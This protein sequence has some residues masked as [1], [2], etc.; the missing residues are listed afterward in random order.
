MVTQALLRG[1]PSPRTRPPAR[2]AAW[3]LSIFFSHFVSSQ[4]EKHP[5]EKWHITNFAL[6]SRARL[7]PL[8]GAEAGGAALKAPAAPFEQQHLCSWRQAITGGGARGKAS[9]FYFSSFVKLKWVISGFFGSSIPPRLIMPLCVTEV[10]TH[11]RLPAW[12]KGNPY[13]ALQKEILRRQLIAASRASY[14]AWS[15]RY[16]T[17][18]VAVGAGEAAACHRPAP[19]APDCVSWAPPRRRAEQ[20]TPGAPPLAARHGPGTA[21]LPSSPLPPLYCP[22]PVLV[23]SVLTA[24]WALC[25]VV[26]CNLKSPDERRYISSNRIYGVIKRIICGN[27]TMTK[28]W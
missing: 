3:H 21:P 13:S 17:G 20:V 22:S 11:A 19:R 26:F 15:Q 8:S 7:R 24:V 16:G 18:A 4:E 9:F 6:G 25:T 1:T 27:P 12:S 10:L 28:Q 5:W 14:R 23:M 2:L